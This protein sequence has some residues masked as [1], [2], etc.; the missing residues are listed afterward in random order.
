MIEEL[1]NPI[2]VS[3]GWHDDVITHTAYS[4][5]FRIHDNYCLVRKIFGKLNGDTFIAYPDQ[6]KI[7]RQKDIYLQPEEF[8]ELIAPNDNGKKKNQF[9]TDD[10]I[11][12]AKN[13]KNNS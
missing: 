12:L 6:D 2:T 9:R 5:E 3:N 1:N 4:F 8:G 13:S 11:K 7:N 10:I